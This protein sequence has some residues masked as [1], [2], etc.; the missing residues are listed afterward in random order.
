MRDL[1]TNLVDIL[2]AEVKPAVGCTEPVAVALACA[3]AKELLGEE[4]VKHKVL[5]SP[6]VYKNAMCVGIPGTDRLGLKIAVAMGFVGGKSEDGLTL[7][8]G[9]TDE[10]VKESE[11]YV[12]ENPISIEPLETKEKVVIEVR[13]EGKNN[14]SR[15]IIKT[16]H[17]NFVF[18][19]ANGLVL[20][21]E[22]DGFAEKAEAQTTEKKE[23][24]MDTITI[25]EIVENV[26]NL[27][28]ED[29]KF[30]LDG[31]T[32]NMDMAKY[33]LENEIGI[34]V[35]RGIKESMEEGLLGDGIMT[36]AMLLTAAASDA[37]MGG[38][39]L[40]VMSSNGSGNHGLTAILP[41]VAYS[42]K[43][44]QSDEKLAKALAISHL[45]TAYVKNFTGRLSAVCG[46]GVAAST[47]AS[48][49][50]AWLMD[51]KINHIYGAIENMI[52]DLSGMICDGAK[53]GCALKLSSAASAAVQSA[54][55]AKQGYAV[56]PLNGIVGTQVEQSIQN[57]GR[58]SD[59]GMQIT[60]EIILNVMNDMNKVD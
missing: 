21:D 47:G 42:S 8:E 57:L 6:N 58:V 52:A 50:I 48:A 4:V 55:I 10:Q 34:G 59:K 46:C 18:L 28:L 44:P 19:Q 17:D 33:G 12:D 24:I 23:N 40:P 9:L 14:T 49:G 11:R 56:P 29:I 5:V 20:L 22:V 16:K 54:V 30:L 51:G 15:V 45:V 25:Q 53:A 39:K 1:R 32:M 26:E 35:G 38:A 41:I 37:R 60:D 7:L 3:K 36:E 31:V 2:K 43:Y 27:N 13:L